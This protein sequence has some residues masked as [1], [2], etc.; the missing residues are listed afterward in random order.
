MCLL[1]LCASKRGLDP[2]GLSKLHARIDDARVSQRPIAF[3]QDRDGDGLYQLGIHIGRYEPIFRAERFL[4]DG[5][6]DFIVSHS[7]RQVSLAGVGELNAFEKIRA[8]L[9]RAGVSAELDR[10]AILA[11]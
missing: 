7:E 10:S 4:P 9:T 2:S 5:L 1:V 11:A 6:I 8:I 3:V